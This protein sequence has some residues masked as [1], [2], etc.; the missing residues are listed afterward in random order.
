MRGERIRA[1]LRLYLVM[2]SINCKIDP[3][4]VLDEAIRGGITLFQFREKG[5]GALVGSEKAALARE[6]N[7][8]CRR[9]SIPFIVN[10]D[11]ELALEL[12]ADGIHVGQEDAS[13][14]DFAKRFAHKII[15]VSAHNV[16]EAKL[17]CEHGASY[18]G[19]GPIYA[20]SSK[21]DAHEV[22]GPAIIAE[23]RRQGIQLPLVGIGGIGLGNAHAVREAGADGIAV[24]SAITAAASPQEA[25]WQ[26]LLETA[27]VQK[28]NPNFD[29]RRK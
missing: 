24:I 8:Q 10:D 13:V 27:A 14:P 19:V 16:A 11:V 3:L 22:Q 6:L 26:L 25:A 23:L 21:A 1:L 12:N 17:A 9:Q 28:A 5:E 4:K 2:G 29:Q 15:G 7:K 20:T 18:I